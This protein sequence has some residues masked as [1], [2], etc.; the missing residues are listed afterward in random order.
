[1]THGRRRN[2]TTLTDVTRRS[3]H[4]KKG[5]VVESGAAPAASD[6]CRSAHSIALMAMIASGNGMSGDTGAT[7]AM[8]AA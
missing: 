6:L 7:F 3:L 5:M 2:Y 4:D 1:M 8:F